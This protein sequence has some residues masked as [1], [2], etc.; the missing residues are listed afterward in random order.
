MSLNC[1]VKKGIKK[2]KIKG[3]FD[4]KE[5]L[6]KLSFERSSKGSFHFITSTN[7]KSKESRELLKK[8]VD[9]ISNIKILATMPKKKK[10]WVSHS[11]STTL[12]GKKEHKNDFYGT[13][14]ETN[15]SRNQIELS[16]V[17]QKNFKFGLDSVAP[18]L[19]LNYLR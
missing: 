10:T 18:M 15:E 3:K 4:S 11:T 2:N 7:K 8:S 5:K 16:S 9:L 14:D 13:K 1:F 6:G 19:N 12:N 17:N